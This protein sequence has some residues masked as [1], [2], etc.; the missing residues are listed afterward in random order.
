MGLANCRL[1]RNGSFKSLTIYMTTSNIQPK[2]G[3]F[4]RLKTCAD[5][6]SVSILDAGLV[7][8]K[9]SEACR[10]E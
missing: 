10:P 8:Q 9:K 2:N 6:L 7:A 5:G 4:R 1:R 3:S